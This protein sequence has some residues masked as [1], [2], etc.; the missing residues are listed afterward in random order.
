MRQ[1]ILY[2]ESASSADSITMYSSCVHLLASESVRK[3]KFQALAATPW[4]G[5]TKIPHTLVGKGSIA[6][7]AAVAL[8][9]RR[10]FPA[11]KCLKKRKDKRTWGTDV[12]LNVDSRRL[13]LPRAAAEFQVNH[14]VYLVLVPLKVMKS[15][16]SLKIIGKDLRTSDLLRAQINDPHW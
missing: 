13:Q 1:E 12:C 2:P 5:H 3:Y 10:E 11:I 4:F 6:L 9:R 15:D 14:C 7:A 8:P 16:W